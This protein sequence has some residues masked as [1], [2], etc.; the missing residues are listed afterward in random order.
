SPAPE[1]P[2]PNPRPR[3]RGALHPHAAIAKPAA[4][5]RPPDEPPAPTPPAA[6][7]EDLLAEANAARAEHRWRD[8]DALYAQVAS[9]PGANRRG[10]TGRVGA[11]TTRREHMGDRAGAARRFRA[12]LAAGP[13]DALAEDARWGLAE[14]ARALGDTAAELQALDDFLAHHGSSPRAPR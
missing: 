3:H 5:S 6:A 13:R 2:P 7:P 14:S 11:A 4:S 1:S 10:K 12:A 8:A 9:G